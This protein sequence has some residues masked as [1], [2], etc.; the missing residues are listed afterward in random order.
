MASDVE[1]AESGENSSENSSA[2]AEKA[3][4]VGKLRGSISTLQS[5]VFS[6]ACLLCVLAIWWYVTRGEAEFRMISPVILPSPVETFQQLRP[7][8]QDRDLDIN[9]F[10]SLKRVVFGF[11]LATL[12]GVP[13]G[14]LCGCFPRIAAFFAPVTLFGRNIPMA[15]L[16]PLTFMFFG[17]G[18][19]QKIMFI[20]IAAVAFIISDSTQAIRDVGVKYIDTSYTL[21]ASRWQTILKVLVPLAMPNVFNSLRLLF[22]L[23]FGYI[24]LAEVVQLGGE[25]GGL[26]QIINT[27]RRRGNVA[28]ILIVLMLIPIVAFAI[29]RVLLWVQKQLFPY[30]YGGEG[31]L[32][33]GWK[34][35]LGL[36]GQ[37]WA[38]AL[39]VFGLDS[40]ARDAEEECRQV[41]QTLQATQKAKS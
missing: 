31:W 5:I 19:S 12:V 38:R 40:K 11:T 23:A 39:R 25:A 10:V 22:G 37:G 17:A 24:M 16:I 18:E 33:R 13:L 36:L 27:S 3:R 6:A 9:T 28:D 20:F 26:G 2:K 30:C 7:M 21:G 14:V 8:F 4:P 29:D 32:A 41:L 15:A 34:V 1:N 35:C